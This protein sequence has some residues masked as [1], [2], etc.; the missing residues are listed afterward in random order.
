MEALAR[1]LPWTCER[2]DLVVRDEWL[3]AKPRVEP[4]LHHLDLARSA[5]LEPPWPDAVLTIGRRPSM[6]A[7][8]VRARSGGRTRI[9][10][11][12]KPS[13]R[14]ADFDLVIGSAETQ[15]PPL[16]NVFKIGLPLMRVDARAVAR[17]GARWRPRLAALP[18]P[19]VGFLVGGPT[20]PFRFD[21]GVVARLVE[22]AARV[23]AEGGTPYLVTSRRTPT[24]VT[25]A[26]EAGWPA[27]APVHRWGGDPSDNPYL[28][29][30]GLADGLV[31]SA[32]SVSMLVEVARLG[33]PLAILPLPTGRLG[34]LDQL[35]RVGTRRLF[36]PEGE[37]ARDRLRRALA[38]GLFRTGLVRHTRDFGAVHA[39][40][41]ERGL[42]VLAD[43]PFRAPAAAVPDDA[44]LA[45]ARVRVLL[46]GARAT[47]LS[48]A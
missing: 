18:R 29:L 8:W 32:D 6:A 39:W 13:G 4:S 24:A 47:G 1:A 33:R 21:A 20:G 45:A 28:A 26:L 16:P 22:R 44:A 48:R 43:E 36:A 9:V 42:A 40:L 30:L 37:R 12:G 2:K 17:E 10:L 27:A 5:P 14:L 41:L 3:R 38:R 7:L 19:L 46:E 31:V 25:D 34:A 11:L 15:L 35:R 23:S